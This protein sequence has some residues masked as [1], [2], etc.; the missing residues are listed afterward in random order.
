[1]STDSCQVKLKCLKDLLESVNSR[2]YIDVVENYFE[3]IRTE[4]DVRCESIQM[5]LDQLNVRLLNRLDQ[6]ES[7]LIK[8]LNTSTDFDY[9]QLSE[10]KYFRDLFSL[11]DG[12][13][14]ERAKLTGALNCLTSLGSLHYEFTAQK[15]LNSHL[16]L[17]KLS[18]LMKY[19]MGMCLFGRTKELA[20]A[21]YNSS[22]INIFDT[23]H[24][25]YKRSLSISEVRLPNRVETDNERFVY[26]HDKMTNFVYVYEVNGKYEMAP[27]RAPFI[28]STMSNGETGNNNAFKEDSYLK[29]K[30]IGFHGDKLYCLDYVD[31]SQLNLFSASGQMLDKIGFKFPSDVLIINSSIRVGNDRVAFIDKYHIQIH[32]FSLNDRQLL[33]KIDSSSSISF[34]CMALV[35]NHLLVVYNNGLIKCYNN[36]SSSSSSSSSL[37]S[38]NLLVDECVTELENSQ[39]K[40][41]SNFIIYFNNKLVISFPWQSQL[42]LISL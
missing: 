2:S 24:L 20:I 8:H 33:L 27:S 41:N 16:R 40:M 18:N 14:G 1:M 30:D 3:H 31:S 19:P 13:G 38:S 23:T 11:L 29:C 39:L 9:E 15:L 10:A 5:S 28:L 22:K 17:V 4:I 6:H 36:N 12:V 25:V 42:C 26:V 32:L 21:D 7:M 35:D 37:S 34:D